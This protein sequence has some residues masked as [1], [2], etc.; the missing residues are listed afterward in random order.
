MPCQH[1]SWLQGTVLL[2]LFSIHTAPHHLH[3]LQATR[4]VAQKYI[5]RPFLIQRRKFDLRSWCV[6]TAKYDI[7]VYQ[8]GVMRTASEPYNPHDLNDELSHLTNHCIQ[9]HGP[10]FSKF[11]EGNEMWYPLFQE[12]LDRLPRGAVG[13]GWS[14]T[15]DILPQV[16]D[17][18]KKCLLVAKK[19]LSKSTASGLGGDVLGCFQLFGFDFMVDE[20]MKVW[21][22]EINGSPASAEYLLEDMMT[23]LI[24]TVVAPMFPAPEG[25]EY[26]YV[27][28][29][30]KCIYRN[31][32]AAVCDYFP[33]HIIIRNPNKA[34]VLSHDI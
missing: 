17:Q 23:N 32:D 4:Y 30:F 26:P 6:V 11:E 22:I 33:P 28:D 20:D 25:A 7:L 5:E 15:D 3:P 18:I 31:S 12:Y 24:A 14:L 13:H 29:N 34:N 19:K 9:E 10:N 2:F 16:N 27:E 8:K 21:L 1:L